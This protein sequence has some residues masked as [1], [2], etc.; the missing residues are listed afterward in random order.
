[1]LSTLKTLISL[2]GGL[3]EV[4]KLVREFIQIIK[5]MTEIKPTDVVMK[6]TKSLKPLLKKKVT[7]RDREKAARNIAKLI[8]SGK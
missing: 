1:M 4:I 7:K 2:I 6:T 8:S 3:P 5:R